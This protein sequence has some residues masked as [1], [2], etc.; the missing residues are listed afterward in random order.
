MCVAGREFSD[1]RLTNDGACLV[2][3][4]ADE[5][6]ASLVLHSFDA[7][8][9]DRLLATEPGL[10]AARG[11]GGGSWCF[12]ADETAIVYVGAAGDLWLQPIAG[13]PSRQLTTAQRD[14]SSPCCGENFV[15]YEIDQ[16]EIHQL[17]FETGVDRR[18]DDG[19]ADFCLDPFVGDSGAIRWLAWNVPDMPWDHSRVQRL[20]DG[21]VHDLTVAGGVQQP[22]E[23]PDGRSICVRDDDGWLNVWVAGWPAVVEPFEHA[24]P[25]WGPGQRTYA[26]SPDCTRVAFVRNER[27]FGRL[28]VAELGSLPVAV[29]R[30]VHG[31]LSWAANRLASVRTGART[32]QEVVVYDTTTWERTVVAV[33]GAPDWSGVD[34]VE[35]KAVSVAAGSDLVHARLYAAPGN[36]RGLLV[37]VH[38]GPTDQWPVT[39]IPRFAYWCAQGWNILVPDHRGSTG[40]G[41]AYQQALRRQWGVLDVQDTL[42]VTKHAQQVG[43]GTARN[44]VVMGS[45]AGGFNALEAVAAEPE[46][47]AAAVVLYPVS[48]LTDLSAPYRFE[49]HYYDSLIGTLPSR[50]DAYRDRSPIEHAERFATTPLM[51][52]HGEADSVV[53]VEQSIRFADRVRA[54]GG[55]VELHVYEGEGHGFRQRVNQLADYQRVAGFL[56]RYVPLASA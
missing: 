14:V 10:R 54:A 2:Y 25:T 5:G 37:W 31:Q 27:G 48:D 28:C 11:L 51:I 46:L 45:S 52:S 29:A 17:F 34:L 50:A 21:E 38:G 7:T 49:Q 8:T 12:T 6:I 44:T 13:G 22:R 24:R 47:F 1:P 19:S 15:V 18:I 23:M 26:W 53:P 30:G 20:I 4:S 33:G 43:W 36:S 56:A 41:R 55:T 9:P 40:H 42:L 16:A 3:A 35:P 39:F 32:P